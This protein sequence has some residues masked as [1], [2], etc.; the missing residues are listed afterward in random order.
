MKIIGKYKDYYDYIQGKYG[1]DE[2]VILDRRNFVW[3][4]PATYKSFNP[5]PYVLHRFRSL[6][7]YSYEVLLQT[8]FV[9]YLIEVQHN[10]DGTNIPTLVKKFESEVN[11]GSCP[12]LL[13]PPEIT[14]CISGAFYRELKDY[15]LDDIKS[16]KRAFEKGKSELLRST[17]LPI[18][19]DTFIPKIISAEEVYNNIYNYLLYMKEPKVVDTRTNKQKIEG[20]GFDYKESFRNIK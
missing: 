8:G 1:I 12:V 19:K 16:I 10:L 4:V 17:K 15:N 7:E 11:I 18:L 20:K 14:Y 6:K 9:Q 5:D 13:M 3:D 2:D